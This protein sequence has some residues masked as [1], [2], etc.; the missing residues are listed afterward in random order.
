M[1]VIEDGAAMF[2]KA[3]IYFIADQILYYRWSFQIQ[4]RVVILKPLKG[5]SAV[6]RLVEL[7]FI[8][9]GTPSAS[10]PSLATHPPPPP[11]PV[12]YYRLFRARP[13]FP[14]FSP[15]QRHD[16]GQHSSGYNDAVACSRCSDS[17]QRRIDGVRKKNY[18]ECWRGM[19]GKQS[20]YPLLSRACF[21]LLS[22]PT[23]L[24][25]GTGHSDAQTRSPIIHSG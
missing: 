22:S 18:R 11:P 23:A 7:G 12:Y 5:R 6:K 20:D 2:A 24:T 25:P 8:A 14:F 19:G 10:P 4:L 21:L 15:F 13:K 1:V 17:G 9:S 16:A 3:F